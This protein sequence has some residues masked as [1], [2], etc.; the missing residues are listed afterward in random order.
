MP[1]CRTAFSSPTKSACRRCSFFPEE[2]PLQTTNVA[3]SSVLSEKALKTRTI[4]VRGQSVSSLQRSRGKR[5]AAGW[6]SILTTRY[7]SEY[8]TSRSF[9]RHP[10]PHEL[11]DRLALNKRRRRGR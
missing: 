7:Y 8:R 2:T 4:R 6:H 3:T 5:R 9:V 10:P 11:P 1:S